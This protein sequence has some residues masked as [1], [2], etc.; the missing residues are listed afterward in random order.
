M[1]FDEC[2]FFKSRILL[3]IS[4]LQG[5]KFGICIIRV[6]VKNGD[7]FRLN[8]GMAIFCKNYGIK[9]AL[10]ISL[11]PGWLSAL[12]SAPSRCAVNQPGAFSPFRGRP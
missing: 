1:F 12:V 10:V 8:S 9:L 6:E 5:V 2:D 7:D 3:R 11:R 4:S